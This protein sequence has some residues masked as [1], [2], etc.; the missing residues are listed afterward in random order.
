MAIFTWSGVGHMPSP[1]GK[2]KVKPE[3]YELKLGDRWFSEENGVLLPK[4]IVDTHSVCLTVLSFSPPLSPHPIT[5]SSTRGSQKK[6]VG[7]KGYCDRSS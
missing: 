7:E 5:F 6:A 4:E 3:P 1:G 2:G